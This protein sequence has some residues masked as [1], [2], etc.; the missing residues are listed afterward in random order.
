MSPAASRSQAEPPGA[1]ALDAL[2][3]RLAGAVPLR[4]APATTATELDAVMRLRSEHVVEA[5]WGD[6]DGP[7][8][9]EV[10]I[11]AWDGEALAGTIRLILPQTG[12]RL[13]V[14]RAFDLDIEPRG[15]VVEI[16]RL[17]IPADRRGDRAHLTWGTLFAHAWFEVRARGLSVLAG[18]AT[19]SLIARY[20]ALGLPFEVLGPARR[21]WGEDRHPVRLDPA[22]VVT[23]T[24]YGVEDRAGR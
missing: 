24:W 7:D 15:G 19:A 3:T 1:A 17:L 23:P 21:H 11:V 22:R 10:A 6:G 20:E 9:R 13:P 16:G 18:A 5:G 8:A 4:V 14:E 12:L 2:A